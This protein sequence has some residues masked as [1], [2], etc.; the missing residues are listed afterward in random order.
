MPDES[1]YVPHWRIF[2]LFVVAVAILTGAVLWWLSRSWV[3]VGCGVCAQTGLLILFCK[4]LTAGFESCCKSILFWSGF[5]LFVGASVLD[6]IPS[7]K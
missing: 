6:T 7:L 1:N 3:T 2:A 4:L 5:F